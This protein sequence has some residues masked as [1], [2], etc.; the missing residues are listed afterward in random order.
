MS[1]KKATYFEMLE[2]A[3]VSEESLCDF[4]DMGCRFDNWKE[5]AREYREEEITNNTNQNRTWVNGNFYGEDIFPREYYV[6]GFDSALESLLHT[7]IDV[8]ILPPPEIIS[9]IANQFKYYMQKG[10]DITLE[11]AFFG[12]SKGKGSYSYRKH[13][14]NELYFSFKTSL[15]IAKAKNSQIR[16]KE[17]L[18]LGKEIT[19]K[20]SLTKHLENLIGTPEYVVDDGKEIQINRFY[21][22]EEGV[23]FNAESFLRGFRRW[24]KIYGK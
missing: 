5:K 23:N 9:I 14:E 1:D 13:H 20:I 6:E 21:G 11:E 7:T 2:L 12:S 18:E 8:D 24:K 10:G 15:S 4:F 3:G 17:Y 16:A 22:L 19:P